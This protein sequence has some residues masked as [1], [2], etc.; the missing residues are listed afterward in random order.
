[1]SSS[2]TDAHHRPYKQ[3]VIYSQIITTGPE[4]L[5]QYVHMHWGVVSMA[6]QYSFAWS[7]QDSSCSTTA[8][9]EI[10]KQSLSTAAGLPTR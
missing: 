7:S 8:N 1:M 3:H 10:Y 5:V 4:E 9:K 2:P 6:I